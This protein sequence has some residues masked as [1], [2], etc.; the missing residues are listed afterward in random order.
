[1]RIIMGVLV[2]F[3][4]ANCTIIRNAYMVEE[5]EI[6]LESMFQD[7]YLVFD[8]SYNDM[9]MCEF[10]KSP[11]V[12]RRRVVHRSRGDFHNCTEEDLYH[13]K[14]LTIVS[15]LR[16]NPQGD[17]ISA[18]LIEPENL[19]LEGKRCIL[20]RFRTF[21]FEGIEEYCMEEGTYTYKI[22]VF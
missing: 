15:S 13:N 16:L 20:E 21:K 7:G 19:D 22:T 2:L 12:I 6:E 8:T 18:K 17:V 4:L 14:Q 11:R 1:M 9:I 5:D 10:E 3:L